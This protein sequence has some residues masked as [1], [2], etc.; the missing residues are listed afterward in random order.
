MITHCESK[1]INEN[2]FLSL[3]MSFDMSKRK[4][5]FLK[6]IFVS[7]AT[8]IILITNI[9]LIILMHLSIIIKIE[10]YTISRRLLID[11]L[12]TKFINIFFHDFVETDK[13]LSSSY[14]RCRDI[15]VRWHISQ[16]LTYCL[17]CFSQTIQ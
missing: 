13:N 9:Y 6:N 7:S 3:I 12:V 2:K 4:T 17:I 1:R 10:S 11:K 8:S 15:F 16:N 14:D 5:I